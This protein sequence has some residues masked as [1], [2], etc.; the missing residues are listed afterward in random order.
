MPSKSS[1]AEAPYTLY[2][3]QIKLIEDTFSMGGLCG[4]CLFWR[5]ASAITW[6]NFFVRGKN[7]A[8]L[9]ESG[10][11]MPVLGVNLTDALFP[12]VVHGFRGI[13]V[14]IATYH[15]CE[16]NENNINYIEVQEISFPRMIAHIG[17]PSIP[18]FQN[19]PWQTIS[20]THSGEKEYGG[21]V[22]D[23]VK[24]LG[25]KLNFTYNVFSPPSN[26]TVKFT[27]NETAADVVQLCITKFRFHRMLYCNRVFLLSLD[28]EKPKIF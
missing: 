17:I 26:H 23:I 3:L 24:Y 9:I 22:F 5:F 16:D 18:S 19:P 4:K 7:V 27:R 25:R 15:V 14:P 10:T 6:G 20:L 1:L 2:F 13:N 21:L 28:N 12:H 8:H 11:W